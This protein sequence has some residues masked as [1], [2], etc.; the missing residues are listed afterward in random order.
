MDATLDGSMND[1]LWA[2]EQRYF[3]SAGRGPL[4]L[5]LV[6]MGGA[7]LNIAKPLIEPLELP[8]I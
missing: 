1:E 3:G 6:P 7:D 2:A 8:Y 5:L 4:T